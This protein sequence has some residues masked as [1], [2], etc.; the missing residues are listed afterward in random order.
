[1]KDSANSNLAAWSL[2]LFSNTAIF[3][4]GC[5][6]DWY[7]LHEYSVDLHHGLRAVKQVFPIPS[8]LSTRLLS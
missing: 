1:M 3:L 8:K 4:P 2:F 5:W 7:T 6:F